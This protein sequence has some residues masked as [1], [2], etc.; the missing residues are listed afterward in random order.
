MHCCKNVE[1]WDDKLGCACLV[2]YP[3]VAIMIQTGV[4]DSDQAH[5][6][7]RYDRLTRMN[8]VAAMLCPSCIGMTIFQ[9][10]WKPSGQSVSL[11]GRSRAYRSHRLCFTMPSTAAL[12]AVATL[13]LV[14]Q[15]VQQLVQLQCQHYVKV[16]PHMALSHVHCAVNVYM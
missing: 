8:A 16:T 7:S 14:H 11:P 15:T 1:S 2:H 13:F 6:P 10:T 4:T 9:P 5:G 3:C 12:S